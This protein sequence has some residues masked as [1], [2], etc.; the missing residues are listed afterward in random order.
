[1]KNLMLVPEI[2]VFANDSCDLELVNLGNEVR[3]ISTDISF[4][5]SSTR[6]RET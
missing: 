4:S 1:M 6:T 5:D 3:Q 2:Q